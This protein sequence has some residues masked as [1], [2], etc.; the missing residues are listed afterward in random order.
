MKT[1]HPYI[2]Q[3]YRVP[4]SSFNIDI[5]KIYL[6]LQSRNLAHLQKRV[7]IGGISPGKVKEIVKLTVQMKKVVRK[8]YLNEY[9]ESLV[10]VSADIEDGHDIPFDCYGL[11]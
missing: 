4:K 11:E 7:E 8:N 5:L 10:I 1:I 6:L 3:E 2:L 9:K